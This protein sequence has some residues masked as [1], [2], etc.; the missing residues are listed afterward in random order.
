LAA[1]LQS[2]FFG[3]GQTSAAQRVARTIVGVMPPDFQP[4]LNP[5]NKR[6]DI[7]RPLSYEGETPP[8][9]RSCRH[10]RTIARIRE[11]MTATQA[12]SE[13]TTIEQRIVSGSS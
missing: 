2:G 9:C 3:L 5:F 7:W 12:Q 1:K 11:G 6:V 10:L 8:A 4:I 13:L